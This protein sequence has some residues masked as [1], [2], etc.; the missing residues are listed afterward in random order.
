MAASL[1][2]IMTKK[3]ILVLI[4]IW[5]GWTVIIDFAVVPTVFKVI[6]DFFNA[7]ELGLSLFSKLNNLEFIF[8]GLLVALGFYE[9]KSN[10]T[11]KLQLVFIL[12]AFLIVLT[13]FFYL[14]P[15]LTSLTELWKQAD[16]VNSVS[17]AGIIDIQQEHQL[18]HKI[19]VTLDTLKLLLLSSL[20]GL[21]LF[22]K[23]HTVA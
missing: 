6:N 8:S 4:S 1:V 19:Y 5:W 22:K 18:Y 10:K 17:V 14:T 12:T 21:N 20:L 2:S 3:F 23:E 15:K 7:G 9:L 11:G 13:Y 16:A